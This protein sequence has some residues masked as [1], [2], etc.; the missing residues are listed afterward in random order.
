MS[1]A[2]E[3]RILQ[4][5]I[6]I[7]CLVPLTAGGYGMFFGADIFGNNDI[8]LDSHFRYLSGLLFGIG[9]SFLVSVPKIEQHKGQVRLLTMLV[10]IGGVG[11]LHGVR[12]NGWPDL[13]M[14]MALGME[15]VVTPL[16]CFW[17]GHLAKRFKT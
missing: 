6:I 10:V 2:A 4:I 15:L 13:Y 12:F 9:I 7:A 17:Q 5:I 14:S 8:N 3:K 11:R 1:A 16:L